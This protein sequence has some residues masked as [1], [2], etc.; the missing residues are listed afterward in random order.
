MDDSRYQSLNRRQLLTAAAAGTAA[1]VAGPAM[2][3]P[4]S[5]VPGWDEQVDV[6]VAGS[7]AAGTCA[8][9]EARRAGA[10]VRLLESLAVPGGSSS[11]SGGVVYAGG[12]TSLQRALKVEDSPEAM[13]NYLLRTGSA[14][15]PRE[16]I[17]LYCEQSPE[18]FDWLVAQGVRY[19]EKMTTAKGLPLGDESL[20]YSGSELA[21]PARE[22]AAPAPRGHV[23][24]VP[25]MNGG[26]SMMQVLLGQ[27]RKLGVEPQTGVEVDRLIVEADGRV[28]GAVVTQDGQRK[29]LRARRG[30]VLACG[31][32]I[33]NT[34]M[35]EQYAP[36]LARCSV[37]WGGAGDLGQGINMGIGV[38]A[39]AV[40][41]HEGFAIAPIYPPEEAIAGILVNAAGQRFVAEDAYHAVIGH[42][43]AY[44][45]Q[46]RAYL[47][48]D[49][50]SSYSHPQDNFP[51]VAQS[52]SI[53]G[54]AGQLKLPA[55]ALQNSVA[56]YNRYAGKGLDPLFNKAR[57]YV[58][59][60][61]GPPYK[62][63]DI[64]VDRAFFP[65]HTFGGLATSIDGAVI[66]SFG[67]PIPGLFAAGRNTAGIPTAPYLASG[68][69]VGDAT[70][71][72][73][74]AGIA[75]ARAA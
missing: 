60:L 62:A 26:R 27:L 11:L 64:S 25:G 72:G 48:T 33:H 15:A 50:S 70:F 4:R 53:G 3:L 40:R 73:R 12:G 61:Q 28:A 69:S 31:G 55:G 14:P 17:Q 75:A 74:R 52:S 51:L 42:S 65:A 21:W 45:Q 46:G 29:Y 34:A 63:W 44:Q 30:L 41:M 23:P 56:Y 58:R 6:L 47:I 13:F 20:Y 18:H 36:Q 43:I 54:I 9:I 49:Q 7:G 8:A 22:H 5:S 16:K 19:S 2:A 37:P 32:F 39:A 66:N 1:M 10:S 57:G 35:L 68:L 24:G 59:P 67:D 38:G 71:F